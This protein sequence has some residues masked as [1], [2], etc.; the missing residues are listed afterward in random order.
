MSTGRLT[1][2]GVAAIAAVAFLRAT[3]LFTPGAPSGIDGG[4]WLAFGTF[5]RAGMTYPPL[6]PM[7]FAALVGLTGPVLATGV[8]GAA[9]TAAPALAA[10]GLHAWAGR[11][12][13]GTLAAL[14]IVSS[15]A[16]GEIAAWGGYPQPTATA[17]ALV[18]LV[19]LAAWL[20]QGSRRALAVFALSLTAVV[21]TSHLI[22]VPTAGALALILI[23]AGLVCRRTRWRRVAAAAGIGLVPFLMLAPV[24][25]A[26]F[27]TLGGPGAGQAEDAERILGVGWPLYVVVLL[28]VPIGFAVAM[29]RRPRADAID[30][31]NL[32]LMVAATAAAVSWAVAYLVSREPRLL[33]DVAVLALFGAAAF[34]P[35][36]G[37]A[38]RAPGARRLLAGL[39][40]AA[41]VTLTVTGLSVFRDQVAYYHVLSSDE[42]AAIEWLTDHASAEP[43][44]ILS[45]DERGVPVGWWVEGMVRQ[46]VLFASDLRW[47]RFQS[48][49]DRAKLANEL[50]YR[51]G[52]PDEGSAA[53]VHDAG[54]EFV[55]LPSAAAFGIDPA[56]PPS[57]WQTVYTRGNAVVLVP[58]TAVL[59]RRVL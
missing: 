32:A 30:S 9:A 50:L 28:A 47:L 49:R 54:V 25:A 27:S 31:R 5:D 48:E 40:F 16:I 10:L 53:T 24:Y 51:S 56:G 46:E 22:A 13:A 36:V 6:V 21:A 57:G 8:A 39:G 17:W 11:P 1:L 3:V 19:A 41:V 58:A 52:F 34:V 23:V 45:A 43:R 35:L 29:R 4:N 55:F 18:A 38:V 33:H 14:A 15:R 2:V 42:F 44:S 7:L 37:S 20:I 59:S 26:L 12:V